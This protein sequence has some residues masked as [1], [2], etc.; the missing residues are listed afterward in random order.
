MISTQ[1]PEHA[2]RLKPLRDAPADGLMVTE[3][4]GSIQGESTHAGL[5]CTFIRTTACNLRCTYCDTR[6]AFGHGKPMSLDA[7]MGEVERF[8]LP[9]V[10]VTGGEPLLQANSLVLMTRLCDAGY[11][12]LLETSGSLDIT[13]VDPRVHRIVDLK[14]PSSGEV[15]ANLYSNVQALRPHDEIKFVL[16]DRADYDWAK[17]QIAQHR[18]TER[19]TVLMG[20]VF[21]ALRPV[22]LA[23]WIV[24]DRLRVRMQ[25]QM[26]KVI[27]HPDARGV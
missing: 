15:A 14:T 18:L 6:Y 21:E 5:P 23:D 24:A 7:I 20:P 12:V 10:E 17:E 9:V 3:I 13:P 11:T 2:K 25:I 19:C 27:W 26:H 22:D 1:A 8:G 4:F 16:G